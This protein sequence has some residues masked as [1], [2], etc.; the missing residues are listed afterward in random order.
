MLQEH[1]LE[2]LWSN[3][4]SFMKIGVFMFGYVCG[5]LRASLIPYHRR[6]LRSR[7]H[8]PSRRRACNLWHVQHA[9]ESLRFGTLER[10]TSRLASVYK[11][12]KPLFAS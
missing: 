2:L 7:K 5:P 8:R 4:E 10:Q 11:G 6:K 9:P 12:T 1:V 3:A